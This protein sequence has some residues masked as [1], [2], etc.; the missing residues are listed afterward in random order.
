MIGC[1]LY[2]LIL[3][4][5]WVCKNVIVLMMTQFS[6]IYIAME[7]V[8]T[9]L[10]ILCKPV[11]TLV[12]LQLSCS[13]SSPILKNRARFQR[14]FQLLPTGLG[15]VPGFFGTMQYYGWKQVVIVQQEENLFSQVCYTYSIYYSFFRSYMIAMTLHIF[16]L[17]CLQITSECPLQP[18]FDVYLFDFRRASPYS[19]I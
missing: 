13:S 6:H 17:H 16:S 11:T 5:I 8:S 12:P 2:L 9:F 10:Q 3:S 15:L 4:C 1:P 19:A 7:V 14:Y 18:P